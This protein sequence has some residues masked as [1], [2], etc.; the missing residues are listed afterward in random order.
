[1]LDPLTHTNPDF[2][3]FFKG[4]KNQLGPLRSEY[5][6]ECQLIMAKYKKAYQ[7]EM[8]QLQKKYEQKALEELQRRQ[9]QQQP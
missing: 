2:V 1:M 5:Q 9:Q 6:N 3:F 7:M 4:I 8:D